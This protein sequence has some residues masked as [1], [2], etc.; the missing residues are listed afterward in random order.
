MNP[1]GQ[2]L[3]FTHLLTKSKTMDSTLI[4]KLPKV[5]LHLHLD[6]SVHL[7]LIRKYLIREGKPVPEPLAEFCIAP[8]KCENLL[9]YLHKIDVA[10]DALQSP[11]SIEEAAY[12][13]SRRLAENH[14]IYAEVRYAPHLNNRNG[15]SVQDILD[16]SLRGFEQGRREFGVEVGVILCAL[17]HF[18]PEYN[19]LVTELAVRNTGKIVG[20]DLA[21][22]E[23]Q[24]GAGQKAH[25]DKV[26]SAGIPITIH[27]AEAWGPERLAEALDL[28]HARRIGHGIRLEEDPD[29]MQRVIDLQIPLEL[30]PTSNVQTN[31]TATI[32]THP[33][34]RYLKAGVAI[35][36]NTDAYT[37]TPSDLSGEYELL[38]RTFGWGL[39]E[40]KL[41]QETAIRN[42]FVPD[43]KRKEILAEFHRRWN[44]V[45]NEPVVSGV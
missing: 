1:S 34:D 19:T 11:E 31:A 8:A 14:H 33:A 9:D 29:L 5:E 42:L 28:L 39:K 44:N 3:T 23:N 38:A 41:T 12:F 4:R 16:A 15:H 18:T 7:D 20:F 6:T 21:G 43:G 10:L 27:A 2:F 25:F 40:I 17:R 22:D 35:T 13:L 36:I 32:E 30:C 26:H 45:L 24:S 37:T